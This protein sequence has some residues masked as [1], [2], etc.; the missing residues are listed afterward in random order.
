MSLFNTE[1]PLVFFYSILQHFSLAESIK[2]LYLSPCMYICL[3]GCH[4]RRRVAVLE[5]GADRM[6]KIALCSSAFIW[7]AA[8]F[9]NGPVLLPFFRCCPPI[10]WE[11]SASKLQHHSTPSSI[12]GLLSHSHPCSLLLSARSSSLCLLL[13]VFPI[14][15]LILGIAFVCNS[16]YVFVFSVSVSPSL[17][18]HVTGWEK[19]GG[20]E[21]EEPAWR[22]RSAPHTTFKWIA[23]I[24]TSIIKRFYS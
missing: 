5:N 12:N 19:K 8:D 22:K 2:W 20:R 17:C 13:Y 7:A 11:I 10:G 14:L 1:L 18:Y 9:V 3:S 24:S 15:F 16:H 4:Q 21:R 23:D 6:Q